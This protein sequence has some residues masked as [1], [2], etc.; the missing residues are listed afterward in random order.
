MAQLY[1]IITK[2]AKDGQSK[3]L[4]YRNVNNVNKLLAYIEKQGYKIEYVNLY[5]AKTKAKMYKCSGKHYEQ[6]G[7]DL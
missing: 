5:N 4:K 2:A 3:F 1:N 7:I 6:N